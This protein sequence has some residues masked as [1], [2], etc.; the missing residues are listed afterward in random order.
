MNG[1]Q[2][3]FAAHC[4]VSLCSGAVVAALLCGLGSLGCGSKRA[5]PDAGASARVDA[6][7]GGLDG[8][9]VIHHGPTG[10]DGGIVDAGRVTSALD[11]TVACIEYL[12][13][14]CE[15][16]ARCYGGGEP[17]AFEQCMSNAQFCPDVMFAPGSTRSVEGTWA[18][19]D[20]WRELACDAVPSRPACAKPGTRAAGEPCIASMQCASV[21]C[22]AYGDTCG[23]CAT[24]V[25]PGEPCD[26]ATATACDDDYYCS[27][28]THVCT[29][30][31][32][33]AE[34]SSPIPLGEECELGTS[35]CGSNDCRADGEGVY[36]C[37]PYPT[38]GQDCSEPKT[39]AFGD[40]YCDISQL[41]TAFPAVGESCGVDAFTGTARWC[42]ADA[43]CVGEA[44][45][46]R[47]CQARPGPGE[48][49]TSRCTEGRLCQCDDSACETRTCTR[50][51]YPGESC[52]VPGDR[53]LAGRCNAGVCRAGAERGLFDSVCGADASASQ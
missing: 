11:P 18:C 38:L 45:E 36:R 31:S 46:P 33:G 40:S 26:E 24:I 39:C 25:G 14:L 3:A 27:S 28:E 1:R 5:R 41:C 48:A 52:E 23:V 2:T 47:I 10:S 9:N 13:G 49:C 43:D 15:R 30:A 4:N 22:T 17:T 50:W 32:S 16:S 29:P 34:P 44:P 51:R 7:N 35:S 53:C 6:G 12:R 20:D 19:A 42:A 21:L 8:G 37:A